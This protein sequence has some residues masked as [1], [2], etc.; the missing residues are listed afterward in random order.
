MQYICNGNQHYMQ[1]RPLALVMQPYSL[2]DA[3]Y[4]YWAMLVRNH[5]PTLLGCDIK[6]INREFQVGGTCTSICHLPGS[7]SI[8]VCTTCTPCFFEARQP[9]TKRSP[10]SSTL[11][12]F[13]KCVWVILPFMLLCTR[14][15][16]GA[17]VP[18]KYIRLHQNCIR[19]C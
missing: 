14:M 5:K 19:V 10:R 11:G 13:N 6:C 2:C 16:P 9:Y 12:P 1:S 18:F 4:T 7:P 17:L 3:V 8:K 15:S